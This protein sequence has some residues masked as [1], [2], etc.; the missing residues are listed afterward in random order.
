MKVLLGLSGGVDSAVAAYLLKE[1]GYDVTCCFMRNW[2][3]FANNDIAGNPTIMED[4]CP[5]EQ[6]Y[7]DAK[8]VADHLGLPMMRI[9]FI[10]EYWDYVFQS[11]LKEYE[12]GRTPNPDI[13]CN[14]YIKFD[15]FFKY[16]MDLGFDAVATGHYASNRK[17]DNGFTYLTRALDQNKDQ[18]YFLCQVKSEA[19][20]KT[21]FP[22]GNIEKP[23]VRRIA[24]ELNLESVA[25]KKD[26][27]GI[28][29]IGE[30]NFRQ[31][32]SN[33]LPSKEGDIVDVDTGKVVA[34]HVGVLYYTVGQRKGLNI[35]HEKGP[36]FV[37]G[38]DVYKNILYVCHTSKREWLLSDSCIVSGIN[39]ILPS[40]DEI[41]TK[42]TCK[43]RYRQKDQDIQIERI[44]DTTVRVVYPQK[45]A[46]VTCGQEA[47]FYDGDKCIGGGVIDQVF[48]GDEDLNEKIIHAHAEN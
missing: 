36:W 37:I 17:D 46:S 9:D 38:K 16:A 47:V 40:L 25:T 19:I 39:W 34:K 11:F 5:Q 28:C 24:D 45:I 41:P 22:I 7:L 31:F 6:D 8:A 10:K 27:T 33:Y 12:S 20:A 21:V 18:T 14:K 29:F 35:D 2:D 1:Q 26:S 30:R 42:C 23:E 15:A 32:L 44:D 13:L 4:R 43:F 48:I 3:S